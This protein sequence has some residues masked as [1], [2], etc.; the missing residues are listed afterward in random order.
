M[1]VPAASR[2]VTNGQSF[3]PINAPLPINGPAIVFYESDTSLQGIA[4]APDSDLDLI[5]VHY[6]DPVGASQVSPFF[7]NQIYTLAPGSYLSLPMYKQAAQAALSNDG[8]V[9]FYPG[10]T[11]N[12]VV[13]TWFNDGTVSV[14]Y[15]PQVKVL[16]FFQEPAAL[17]DKRS[18]LLFQTQLLLAGGAQT[19][20][21]LPAF[22]RRFFYAQFWNLGANNATFTVNGYNLYENQSI[23]LTNHQISTQTVASG[24]FGSATYSAQFWDAVE[25]SINGT[26]ADLMLISMQ[27]SDT[28]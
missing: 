12:P 3:I 22:G 23:H 25:L 2:Y 27:L 20:T 11:L 14:P 9:Q 13:N 18:D 24:A 1:T 26:A 5:Q 4:L 7:G 17:P 16:G 15:I 28:E 21:R 8:Q 10:R 6:P 19:I